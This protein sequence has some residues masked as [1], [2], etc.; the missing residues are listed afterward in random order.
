MQLSPLQ[1]RLV[2]SL[3][4]TFC[5][6]VLFS[7]LLVPKGAVAHEFL[8]E[9][10]LTSST[11]PDLASFEEDGHSPDS[12]ISSYEPILNFLGRSIL[13]RAGDTIPLENDKPLAFNIQPGGAPICYIIKK[14]SLGNSTSQGKQVQPRQTDD[15]N[16]ER[17]G[18]E[19]KNA[20]IYIS[21]NTCLQPIV[22]SGGKRSKPPQLIL[23]LSNGTE[24]GCPQVTSNPKGHLA[25][26]FTSHTF[27]EGAVRVSA[28]ATSDIYIGLYAPNITDSFEG[29]YDY[30]VAAS[31]TEYFHQYQSNE[32]EG[33][34]LLWMDSDSTAALLITR[35]LTTE[36][37]EARRIWSEDPP[38]QLYVSGQDWPMLDGLHHSACGLERNA[39]VGANK[40]GT[41]KNNGMVKT[42]MTLRGPGGMPKQQ[43][44]VVG[45]NATTS[46]SGVLVQPAN[47]T[48]NSKRQANG[49]G[50]SLRKPGS[51]VFQGTTFQTNA[52][53]N[54]KVVTDLEFCDEIQYAVPG[55]DGKFNNTELAKVYDKQAKTVYDNFLKVM[56]QIQ[57]EADR[58]S[59]YSLARTCEDCKR[60]YKRWLCTVSFPRCEDF[61]DGSRFSVL[62]NVNQ[63]FPNGTLLPTEIR[64]E[65]AKVPAQNASRNSFIDET[66]QPGPYKEI[67]PCEDICYQVVQSCP[68]MIKFNCPQPGMYGFNVTYGRR[69]ADNTVV[70]CNF[71]GEARTRTSAGHDTIP[72]LALLTCIMSVFSILVMAR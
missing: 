45:L 71:P 25:R 9:S 53:P 69:N 67:M 37:S 66:I 65:L 4:A 46:Y 30:Q 35:N 61:L 51:V 41:A 7:L 68:A 57:C 28:N 27:E 31:S 3:A 22:Q 5:L 16:N 55:N 13:G 14:G 60:A 49:G 54:C 23:F 59:K 44:Y 11:R 43:F 32:T 58:T 50:Q 8:H 26:G 52:A 12:Q 72:N 17:T 70:S 2:A 33:A 36:A 29:S 34:K 64:Q 39:L 38:Y 6:L 48:V 63:A 42:S 62:R 21:A 47:V 15:D 1:S 10:F 18:Q 24:A 20:T 19:V 40:E 56:Q